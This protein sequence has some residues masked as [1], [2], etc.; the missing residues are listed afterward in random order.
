MNFTLPYLPAREGKPRKKGLTMMMDKGL[1]LREAENFC[2]AAAEF[3][4]IV[5]FGFGT[6]FIT[7][8]LDEKISVYKEAG[9]FPYFGGTLF[10]VF[11]IRGQFEE[12]RRLVDRYKLEIVEISDGSM[13]IPHDEKLEYIRILSQQ[14][15]VIS[16]V[17][18]KVSGITIPVEKWVEMMSTELE[19][20][21][22]KVIAEARES[23][24]T[25]IYNADGSANSTLI[26]DIVSKI[27]Q[28]KILW[29][30]PNKSQQAYFIKLLGADVNLGNIATNEVI[31]L[32]T[33]RLGLRGDTFFDFL[34][35]KF[36]VRKLTPDCS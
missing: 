18:Y 12:F 14:T 17:G 21:A 16:E 36:Q 27:E 10:E 35:A 2:D 8:K 22:W 7:R 26:C 20:G 6:A 19:A 34:P 4:D 5:K 33:L 30:A 32:E 25:G 28:D 29:E 15:T 23:G 31:A 11:A 24:N 1:S 9:I 3:T 13:S